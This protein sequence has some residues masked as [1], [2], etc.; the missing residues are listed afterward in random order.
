MEI[1]ITVKTGPWEE[2]VSRTVKQGTT[3]ESLA[4][5]YNDLP[6]MVLAAKVDNKITELTK[7]IECP[8]CIEFMDMRNQAAALI[9]QRSLSLLY[10]KAID[11]VLG[12]VSTHI[13]NSLNKGL[14]TEIGTQEPI[15]NQ[16]VKDIE[17]RMHE[18]VK[19]DIPFI[20][21]VMNREDAFQVLLA[22]DYKEKER[23]L[24]RS[25][26]KQLPFYS[27]LG[28]RNFFYGQMV[29][30]TRYI[31]Y[32]ELR[33]YRR[34][35]L[36]R[37]PHPSQPDKIQPFVDEVQLYK[38]FSE[39]KLWGRLMRISFVGDLN[40]KVESGEYKEIIQISE[41]LHEKRIAQIA[42]MI[43]KQKKRIIL[44][45]GPSSS[46]KTTFARRLN[47]QLRVNGLIPLYLSTDDYFVERHQTPLDE[48]GEKNFED[49]TALDI[50]LFNR[51]MNSLLKGEEVDIPTFDFLNGK[52]VF[53]TRITRAQKG[54]P[55]IIEGIHGLNRQLTEDMPEEEKF[56]IYISPLTQLNIDEHNRIPTTDARMLRRLVRDYQFRG[57]TAQS[58][59]REWP[60]VRKGEDKNIFPY[61]GEADV[62]FNSEHIYE[63]SVL[64][65]YAEPLLQQIKREEPEYG[66]AIRMWKYLQF[67]KTIT[68]D[69][70]IANNSIIREFIGGSIFV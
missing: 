23:M 44:I 41:A 56:K 1:N 38:V 36:L 57:H 68:D 15:T 30:S 14:Y 19:Q 65:K 51:D 64:K 3:I 31:P 66:E 67:F 60:K 49:I 39:A 2:P 62:F 53:G 34:G 43:T 26:V 29:P 17:E 5:E 46:G 52:K 55:I 33:R 16:Q 63:L 50:D 8:A 40:E 70:V 35:V 21:E 69:S 20:R 7:V 24:H 28:F 18:L 10:L 6:Y 37:F 9:Y 54:H 13:E 42:D 22:E 61:N 58:T 25:D 11:D 48:N 59:I 27:L 45:S 12:K 47:I 32:F 4:A